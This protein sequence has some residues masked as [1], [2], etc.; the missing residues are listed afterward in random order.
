MIATNSNKLSVES[1][2]GGGGGEA[3]T[4]NKPS[5]RV[6]KTAAFKAVDLKGKRKEL[7]GATRQ[8]IELQQQNVINMYK[9]MKKKNRLDSVAAAAVVA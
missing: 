6:K 4:Q 1:S 7:P 2:G 3:A 8:M 5:P 9:E